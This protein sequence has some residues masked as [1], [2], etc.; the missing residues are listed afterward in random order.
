MKIFLDTNVFVYGLTQR[1]SNS[2]KI[3]ELLQSGAITAFTSQL[4]VEEVNGV[5]RRLYGREEAYIAIKYVKKTCH[6]IPRKN[7]LLHLD[8]FRGM[9]KEKDL[10]NLV[11]VKRR[12]IRFLVAY[13]RDYK[14]FPEYKSP[15][16]FVKLLGFEES[17]ME[18]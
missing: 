15:K 8:A 11:T 12:K 7:I 18:Y 16:E 10:E 13:D 6:V 9:V 4:V 1:E 5:F 3:L 17:Q 2:A 14:G